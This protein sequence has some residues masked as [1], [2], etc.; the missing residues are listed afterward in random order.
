M[1]EKCIFSKNI[2][3]VC[4]CFKVW[5]YFYLDICAAGL[6]DV[7]GQCTP[8]LRGFYKDNFGVDSKFGDCVMCPVVGEVQMTTSLTGASDIDMCDIRKYILCNLIALRRAKT[9]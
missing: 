4:V 1:I 7:D 3:C 5:F 6:E 9:L 2:A 8:C